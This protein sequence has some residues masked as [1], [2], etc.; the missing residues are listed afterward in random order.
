MRISCSNQRSTAVV[1]ALLGAL[2]LLA[3]AGLAQ[4]DLPGVFGEI[5]DVRVVNVEVVVTGPD[6]NRVRGLEREDFRLVVD[7]EETPIDYFTEVRGGVA[8]EAG[9]STP[10]GGPF[11][12]GEPVGTSYLVFID[13]FFSIARDRNRVLEA[14]E[15]Q[16]GGLGPEDRMAV[17]SFDGDGLEMLTTWSGNPAVLE[18]ALKQARRRSS[19]GLRRLAEQRQGTDDDLRPR[20]FRRA[21]SVGRVELGIDQEHYARLLQQQLRRSVTA[22]SAT[23]RAFASPPGRKV[24]VLLSGGWPFRPAD[25][26]A[27]E[28]ARGSFEVEVEGGRDLFRP[29]TDTANLLGYTIY[30]VDLPGLVSTGPGVTRER[31]GRI[32]FS[33]R[34]RETHS[35][36]GFLAERTGGRAMLDSRRLDAMEEVVRDTRT[37]Y[38]LGFTLEGEGDDEHHEVRVEV[39]NPR[40]DARYRDGFGEFSRR[41]EVTMAMES[42]LLFGNAPSAG[43]LGLRVGEPVRA[44]FRKVEVPIAVAIPLHPLTFVPAG[45]ELVA[46][47]EL[48]VAVRDEN[49]DMAPIPVIPLTLR[50]SERP[51]EGDVEAFR[52]S[53]KLRKADHELVVSIFEPVSETL[54]SA[55]TEI[56]L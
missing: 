18:R 3:G 32:D 17:V 54:L 1:T 9:E 30:P 34:E 14:L 11:R 33:F 27:G 6:G 20:G 50:R 42:G 16:I 28:F 26:V 56:D 7:G 31:P 19:Y 25:Y 4:S 15:G 52:T 51:G 41:T 47:L 55:R 23:L 40:L 43:R 22:A 12:P 44:G 13:D 2:V 24:M 5:L 46:E 49:G 21:P 10:E 36:L 45:D 8:V 39:T 37:Y 38:S 53:L 48:R 35:T 29:L